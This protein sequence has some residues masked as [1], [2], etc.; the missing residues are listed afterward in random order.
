MLSMSRNIVSYFNDQLSSICTGKQVELGHLRLMFLGSAEKF[1]IFLQKAQVSV[2]AQMG[3]RRWRVKIVFK[4]H[5]LLESLK[6]LFESGDTI[7]CCSESF[8]GTRFG[9]QCTSDLFRGHSGPSFKG[10]LCDTLN[11]LSDTVVLNIIFDHANLL[12]PRD[13]TT[14]STE[15]RNRPFFRQGKAHESFYF[16]SHCFTK[17]SGCNTK[18]L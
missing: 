12:D 10:N 14:F 16:R 7:F 5:I 6:Y 8:D 13:R 9:R 15:P 1:K 3:S 4:N 18:D 11:L 17:G 2:G